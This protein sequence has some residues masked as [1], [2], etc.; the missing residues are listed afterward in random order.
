V[1]VYKVITKK[2]ITVCLV[3]MIVKNVQV[4]VNVNNVNL[5]ICTQIKKENANVKKVS[6]MIKLLKGVN[7]VKCI[8]GIA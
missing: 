8:K 4:L 3:V 5:I 7:N 1:I 2:K 6:Y